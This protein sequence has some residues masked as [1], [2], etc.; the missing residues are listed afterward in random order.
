MLQSDRL[1]KHLEGYSSPILHTELGTCYVRLKRYQEA[2]DQYGL[3]LWYVS[4]KIC[5]TA[6]HMWQSHV[7]IEG[8][9]ITYFDRITVLEAPYH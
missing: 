3:A 4:M 9:F 7:E 1:L 5:I 8:Y 6:W 2:M